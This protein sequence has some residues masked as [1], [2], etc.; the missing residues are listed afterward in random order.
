MNPTSTLYA[1]GAAALAASFGRLKNRVDLSRAKHRSLAGH[2]RLARRVARLVP[3]YEYD[4]ARFFSSDG[5][6][7]EIVARRRAGFARLATLY[8]ERFPVT[9]RHTAELEDSVSDLQFTARYR[10]PFQY[11][12][13]VRRHLN[14]G[15]LV[16]S[17][18]GVTVT[19]LDGNRFYDLAGSYGVNVFGHDFYKACMA[20]GSA[21]GDGRNGKREERRGCR[22]RFHGSGVRPPSPGRTTSLTIACAS[23]HALMSSV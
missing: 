10:V 2:S 11:S 23:V 14:A 6:P 1:L 18:S 9:A 22:R 8:A 4:E 7:A 15:A 19:D 16:Q 12:R 5:A 13:F 20:E 3:F 21:R 17:S